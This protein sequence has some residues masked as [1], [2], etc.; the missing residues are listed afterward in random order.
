MKQLLILM[1]GFEENPASI[2]MYGIGD[3]DAVQNQQNKVSELLSLHEDDEMY[4]SEDEEWLNVINNFD[5][6]SVGYHNIDSE[7][8]ELLRKDMDYEEF[9]KDYFVDW[10]AELFNKYE[11]L[12]N[13]YQ[14][15]KG[16]LVSGYQES[17]FA[18]VVEIESDEEPYHIGYDDGELKQSLLSEDE[19]NE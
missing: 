17:D 13:K 9:K 3:K 14:Q 12:L 6:V 11:E 4:F 1:L 15:Q 7:V 19:A 8:V 18:F 10:D 5:W 2:F 16:F